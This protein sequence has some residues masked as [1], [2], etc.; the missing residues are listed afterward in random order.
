[1]I[2]TQKP[3][4]HIA[5]CLDDNDCMP[6]G[7]LMTS[8]LQTQK[9][10]VMFHIFSKKLSKK[11]KEKLRKATNG[12]IEFYQINMPEIAYLK[13]DALY[14]N[15]MIYK[16]AIPL[17]VPKE[18][19]K[20]LYLDSDMLV[21][22]PLDDLWETDVS[23]VSVAC[24]LQ[25]FTAD[26]AK[27]I[28]EL[29]YDDSFGYFNSGMLLMNLK[30]WREKNI[31]GQTLQKL[32]SNPQRDPYR[33][34]RVLNDI[35]HNDKKTVSERFNTEANPWI[36]KKPLSFPVVIHF[37]T[38]RKPWYKD[39]FGLY[40]AEWRRTKEKSLW[41]NERLRYY[42]DKSFSG[43]L[44]TCV[45]FLLKFDA[46]NN[47][48]TLKSRLYFFRNKNRVKKIIDWLADQESKETFKKII[49]WREGKLRGEKP[50]HGDEEKQYFVNDFFRYGEKEVFIDCG[51]FNGDTIQYFLSM[52]IN[53][54]K[55]IAFEPE[56]ENFKILKSNYG[57]NPKFMLINAGVYSK[58][59]TIFFSGSGTVGI[60]SETSQ[61]A[62][63]ETNI[64]VLSIDGL[65]L[66]EKV[67]LI[68]MDIEGSEMEALKGAK[69]TI[70]RDK[71]KLAICIYH[72]NEDMLNIAE[73]IHALV[74]EY[75]LYVRHH[76][77]E[78]GVHLV[79]GPAETVLYATV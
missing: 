19:G 75:K 74:P 22:A 6:A 71:P 35:L 50:F 26:T 16:I 3:L 41:A 55:I 37:A 62:G 51:A 45:K 8:I 1:M 53:Y 11:N 58:D 23:D 5:L 30:R 73:W 9:S 7:V 56:S 34:Q 52:H 59:G 17:L 10:P 44:K 20:I 13:P 42:E 33:D 67:T 64:A 15:A 2:L 63:H 21:T 39:F 68:K 60:V 43:R 31:A 78:Y 61:A 18:M 70:R 4:I 32:D 57:E 47:T 79:M 76:G 66:Q 36:T 24:V 77:R 48:R 14:T 29:G 46:N 65:F 28:N 27:I 38:D 72:S 69:E 49:L 54:A 12:N 25:P 40:I